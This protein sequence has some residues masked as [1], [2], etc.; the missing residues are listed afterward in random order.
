MVGLAYKSA[1]ILFDLQLSTAM[2]HSFNVRITISTKEIRND[3]EKESCKLPCQFH[4][5][6]NKACYALLLLV[7]GLVVS[8]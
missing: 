1:R 5:V 6:G 4:S 8:L 3:R 2:Y 7:V